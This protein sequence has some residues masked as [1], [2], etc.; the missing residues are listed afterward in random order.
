[1]ITSLFQD[2][3]QSSQLL[4]LLDTV[5]IQ[6]KGRATVISVDCTEAAKMCKKLKV[7]LLFVEVDIFCMAIVLLPLVSS[8]E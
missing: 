2:S 7:S 1:M 6:M 4:K 5:S 8:V 3:K